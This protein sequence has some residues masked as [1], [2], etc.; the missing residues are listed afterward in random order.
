MPTLDVNKYLR[1]N[2]SHIH[3]AGLFDLYC[4]SR[5]PSYAFLSMGKIWSNG[6]R[7]IDNRQIVFY[8]VGN[9]YPSITLVN[10]IIGKTVSRLHLHFISLTSCHGPR[11]AQGS[12]M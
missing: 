12:N 9:D 8:P 10:E 11:L 2:V 4:N 5:I 7:F 1:C 3:A 6:G